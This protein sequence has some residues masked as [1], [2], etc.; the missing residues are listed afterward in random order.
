MFRDL[1]ELIQIGLKRILTSRIF[2]LA[3][4]FVCMFAGLV[5]R[6]FDLQIVMGEE[7]QKNYM[8]GLEMQLGYVWNLVEEGAYFTINRAWQSFAAEFYEEAGRLAC[9]GFP[10][11]AM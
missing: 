3:V 8:A 4:I 1:L 6:L 11:C 7:Y 9:E 5:V 2:A 10:E